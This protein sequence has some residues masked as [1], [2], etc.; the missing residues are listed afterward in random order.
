MFHLLAKLVSF[1]TIADDAHREEC[2]QGSLYFKRVLRSLGA[3]T[4][5][6][7]SFFGGARL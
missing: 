3:E 1:K 2:R 4:A 7:S 5:L 6:V